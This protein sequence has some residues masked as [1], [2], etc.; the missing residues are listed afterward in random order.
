MAAVGF[1][2]I[3]AT[4]TERL[5]DT[6]RLG[7]TV[8]MKAETWVNDPAIDRT[9]VERALVA[10]NHPEAQRWLEDYYRIGGPYAGATFLDIAPNEPTVIGPA[11]LLAIQTLNVSVTPRAIRNILGEEG[12]RKITGLLETLDPSLDLADASAG[13]FDRMA[14]L[15]N[16]LK[17]LL[18]KN[19]WVTAAKLTARKRPKL[20]PVRDSVV[21]ASLGLPGRYTAQWPAF[22]AIMRDPRVMASLQHIVQ[23]ASAEEGVDLGRGAPLLRHLD[24]VL[25]THAIRSDE[26]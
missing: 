7:M 23:A 25:W 5:R 19:P 10:L 9:A 26:L 21:V 12:Q 15:H 2:S 16:L 13:D 4:E 24:V 1:L 3:Q 20:F 22:A 8:I 14:E 11:D 6:V 18:G 17:A